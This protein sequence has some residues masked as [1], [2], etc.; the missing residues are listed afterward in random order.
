MYRA[1]RNSGKRTR[2]LGLLSQLMNPDPEIFLVNHPYRRGVSSGE[3]QGARPGA[4]VVGMTAITGAGAGVDAGASRD[5]GVVSNGVVKTNGRVE[6][7]GV[8][9]HAAPPASMHTNKG[10]AAVPVASQIQARSI[11]PGRSLLAL[12]VLARNNRDDK[13]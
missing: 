7:G 10:P 5:T 8:L 12:L 1:Q 11:G 3:I 2:T 13:M 9:K 4:G 6:Q